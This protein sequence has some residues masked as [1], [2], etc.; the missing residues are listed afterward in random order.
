MIFAESGGVL[1]GLM[2][3][4]VR[5]PCDTTPPSQENPLLLVIWNKEPAQNPIYR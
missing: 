4:T 2:G 5:L 3:G 1:E